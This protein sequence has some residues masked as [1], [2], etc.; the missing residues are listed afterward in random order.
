VVAIF[1]GGEGSLF[2][3]FLGEWRVFVMGC[4]KK[5][6]VV[7]RLDIASVE[8]WTGLF[9]RKTL[10]IIRLDGRIASA[11]ADLARIGQAGTS[12]L[13]LPRVRDRYC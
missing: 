6:V 9:R 5:V 1:G 11:A 7:E 13:P 10:E 3:F 2:F 4:I 8:D 12:L